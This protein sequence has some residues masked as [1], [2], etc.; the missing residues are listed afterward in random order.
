MSKG[1]YIVVPEPKA[2][3][4]LCIENID[5]PKSPVLHQG[6]LKSLQAYIDAGKSIPQSVEGKTLQSIRT[7]C[8]GFGAQVFELTTDVKT[9]I[10]SHEAKDLRVY[11]AASEED[12]AWQLHMWFE[13]PKL[14]GYD[15]ITSLEKSNRSLQRLANEIHVFKREV[16]S[17][18]RELFPSNNQRCR[19]PDLRFWEGNKGTISDATG[20]IDRIQ[21]VIFILRRCISALEPISRFR[22]E[23][24]GEPIDYPIIIKYY[25]YLRGITQQLLAELIGQDEKLDY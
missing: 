20:A 23:Y 25:F 16:E 2:H 6:D 1:D 14:I 10:S 4:L 18:H 15:L 13:E 3:D 22:F 12:Q 19:C 17:E 11:D 5:L 7:H 24:P 8:N 21:D 9:F